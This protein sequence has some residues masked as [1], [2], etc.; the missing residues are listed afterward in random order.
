MTAV[1]WSLAACVGDEP[2][3][4]FPNTNVGER[5]S[6]W[7]APREVCAG[8]PI[9]ADCLEYALVEGVEF[10][11]WGGKSERE[12]AQL[13]KKRAKKRPPIVCGTRRGHE[14]HKRRGE[15][16]DPCH[17]AYNADQNERRRK[18]RAA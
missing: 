16:C 3:L 5:G 18:E 13:R 4:W 12:R 1:D 9:V 10:G 11:M 15:K 17:R 7:V 2:E 14:N 8:C 6:A